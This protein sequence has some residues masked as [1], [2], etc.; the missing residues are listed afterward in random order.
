VRFATL[1][2][3][4]DV[5]ALARRLYRPAS[6]DAL[7]DAER[8]LL[9]ANPRLADPAGRVAG[10]VVVVPEVSGAATTDA[11]QRGADLLVPVLEAARERLPDLA[12]T[13]RATLDGRRT[14]VKATIEQLGS[15]ELRQLL[16]E[17]P[18]L[19]DLVAGVSADAKAE[20]ADIDA[21]DALQR[22]A[23]DELGQDLDELLRAVGGQPRTRTTD[24]PRPLTRP[25]ERKSKATRRPSAG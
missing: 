22:Q 7:R 1:A 9:K 11:T 8:A 19:K 18:A 12:E 14:A 6:A 4:E 25:R 2:A 15:A 10:T 21:L 23:V 5:A 24:S 16:R 20:T 13:L 3:N 17:E